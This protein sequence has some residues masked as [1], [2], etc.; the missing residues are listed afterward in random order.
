[1]PVGISCDLGNISRLLRI[2]VLTFLATLLLSDQVDE[3]QASPS[4]EVP[5]GTVSFDDPT[6]T[7]QVAGQTVL[8]RDSTYEARIYFPSG[9]PGGFGRVFNEWTGFEEDKLLSVGPTSIQGYNYPVTYPEPGVVQQSVTLQSDV[10]HHVA[11]VQDLSDREQR[12]YLD[13]QLVKSQDIEPPEGEE[14][15]EDDLEIGDGSGGPFLGAIF[16]DGAIQSSFTGFLDS[17]RISDSARYSGSSFTPPSDDFASDSN[18]LILYNFLQ[19]EFADDQGVMKVKDASGN[20]HDGS[21]GVGFNGATEPTLGET[22]VHS[23]EF[24]QAIQELQPVDDLKE[25]LDDDGMPPVP[26]IAGKPAAMRVYFDEVNETTKRRVEAEG[27]FMGSESLTLDTGCDV[28]KRRKQEGGCQSAD[29]Y[30]TPPE[31]EWEITVNVF[32]DDDQLVEHYDFELSS[33]EARGLTL[34]AVSVCDSLSAGVI[35]LWECEDAGKL[36]TAVSQLRKMAPTDDVTVWMA[37]ESIRY[38]PSDFSTPK[39]W[40]YRVVEDIDALH[41]VS[42]AATELLLGD[43]IYYYGMARP[44]VPG[45]FNGIANDLP[46]TG[47]FSRSVAMS[48]AYTV[49]PATVAHETS[50]MFGIPHTTVELP[51]GSPGCWASS[52]SNPTWPYA[53]NMLRSG[54]APGEVEVGFDVAEKKALPGDKNFEL[55]GYCHV[56]WIS[57]D[58]TLKMLSPVGPLGVSGAGGGAQEG[59]FWLISGS[60]LENAVNFR[61]LFSLETEGP[62]GTGSGSMKIVVEDGG[63]AAL[64]TRQ[65]NTAQASP[66]IPPDGDAESGPPAFSEML[67]VQEGAARIVVFD[68]TDTEIGSIVLTGVV[69]TVEVTAAVGAAG[70]ADVVSVS[71]T[72]E[73]ADSDDHTIWIDY[74]PDGGETWLN[75]GMSLSGTNL[76]LD[77]ATLPGSGNGLIR[78]FASDGVNTGMT[79]SQPFQVAK[80]PPTGEIIGPSRTSFRVGDLVW[81]EAAAWDIDDRALA[82]DAISWDSDRDG[83]LGTGA[84][85]PVY[86]LSVG[87][88]EI[89]MSV[90]DSDGQVV[91]DSI[92]ITVSDSPLIEGGT[93]LIWGDN[94]CS[95]GAD[96]IDGLLLL[97]FDAGLIVNTGTCP[98]LGEVVD[99]LSESPHPWGD[100]DCSG[101]VTPI[102]SLKVLRHD[103]GLPNSQEEGC[104]AIGSVVLIVA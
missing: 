61:P 95:G 102:D 34:K 59:T 91:T 49:T 86:N 96:P 30:F 3:G 20:G 36:N 6:D 9:G 78:V 101:A 1:M 48:G 16:R 32:D 35:P 8:A 42:D 26:L 76:G 94:N 2:L 56:R 31:G 99:V 74:S 75:Q 44:G 23:V 87:I 22:E 85:N 73:D 100:V 25:D 67:P 51:G 97:R 29:F 13:G 39:D 89:T 10:W 90:R 71:W 19:A 40:W 12:I 60:I 33:V 62:V 104:P 14:P 54:P 24:T 63:G 4:V 79:I 46:S 77:L 15:D 83:A 38:L 70:T 21:L 57:Q 37:N 82:A 98:E 81:L 17:L 55:M 43:E 11:F 52:A 47:A 50:H 64:F 93:E 68:G 45:T 92:V 84:S 7:I 69:P 5:P 103:A 27:E 28:E 65:F 41:D 88:H 58:T 66:D 18:T 80:K 53:D 72:I